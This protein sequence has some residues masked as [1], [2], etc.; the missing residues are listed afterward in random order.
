MIWSQRSF[1]CVEKGIIFSTFKFSTLS[2]PIRSFLLEPIIF[3]QTFTWS[4]FCLSISWTRWICFSLFH[5][6]NFSLQFF[7]C[8]IYLS[9]FLT[10][11]FLTFFSF[12]FN[13]E[14]RE[15]K[16]FSYFKF[17]LK[18]ITSASFCNRREFS[19]VTHWFATEIF[20]S[21]EKVF[22]DELSSF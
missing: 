16:C 1:I 10:F 20:S 3:R 17:F 8:I 18:T 19:S 15:S 6:L 2:A 22:L 5:F 7:F 9:K 14:E 13:F 12:S 4:S 11:S 21:Y